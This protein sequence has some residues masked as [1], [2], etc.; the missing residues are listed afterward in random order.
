MDYKT[1]DYYRQTIQ[2]IS[3]QTKISEIYISKKL[4]E[5]AKEGKGKQAH[6]GYYLIGENKNILY[7][8][9][10]VK[11]KRIMS[12]KQKSKYYISMIL[13]FTIIIDSLILGLGTIRKI[14]IWANLIAF[15]ILLVPISEFV[16]Q[17]MQYILS[18]IVKPKLIPKIDFYDGIDEENTTMVVIPTIIKT[19]EKVQEL[20]KK[21]EIFYLANKSE[22]LYFCL[23]G[24]CL[25]SSKQVETFD[26][27]IINEGK[28]QA[29]LLN[30]KY[31]KQENPIF[32]F[33]YRKRKWNE[34]EEH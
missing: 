6:I 24:D 7:K 1:K 33:I 26:E 25:E 14:P 20:M 23:L 22:N 34:K 15:I 30:K 11:T 10:E 12:Q 16:I 3:E 18:K 4:L 21:L 5:L 19:K 32:H 29:E 9:L 8:K 2:K 31:E 27:E 28:I 17:I 13:V